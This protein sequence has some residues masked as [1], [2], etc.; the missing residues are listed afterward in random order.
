MNG[1]VN[2]A[3]VGIFVLVL[4]GAT[5]VGSLWLMAGSFEE[6]QYDDYLV[7]VQESVS[8]LNLGAPVKY[9][10]V[11]VGRVADIALDADNPQRVRLQLAIV[12]GTP[13]KTDTRAMLGSQ[14]LTGLAYVELTGGSREAPALTGEGEAPP[15]IEDQPSLLARL[16]MQLSGVITEA[17]AFL[18]AAT[19]VFSEQNRQAFNTLLTRS[20]QL[21]TDLGQQEQDLSALLAS[22]TEAARNIE[23]ATAA[24]PSLLAEMQRAT[25]VLPPTLEQ[26]QR[27]AASVDTVAASVGT[28]AQRIEQTVTQGG[29]DLRGFTG[30]LLPELTALAGEWRELS[31]SLQRIAR[32]LERE[33]GS[34]LFGTRNGRPGPGE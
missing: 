30:R 33:P 20:E 9:R 27:A 15:V 23:R 8:G 18:S 16:D 3:L 6:Q 10:G 34:L 26:V 12:E 22:A 17:R 2:Y 7:Y 13:I 4:I 24:M 14:G 31:S 1:K 29:S 19:A 28:M 5:I 21:V 32:M 25:A 11:E